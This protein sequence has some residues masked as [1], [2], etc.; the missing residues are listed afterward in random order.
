[1]KKIDLRSDTVT[2]P[3][4]A[5]RDAMYKAEL[6]D[7]VYGED[8]TVNLLQER[9]AQL[10]G[11]DAALF[12]ASGTM[13][14]LTAVLSH[15]QR[16]DEV[17][18]GSR[19][20]IAIW[21]QAGASAFGGVSLRTIANEADG[22]L[23]LEQINLCINEDDPHRTQT[24][25]IALENTFNGQPLMPA[26][27]RMVK[28]LALQNGLAVHLDGAR[29]FNASRVLLASIEEFTTHV[30]SVQFCFSKGLAAPVGSIIC[31][32]R[33]FITKAKRVRKA[34]G[35]GMR[36]AGVLA[37]GCL[38]ALDNMVER[39]DLDHALAN[40]LADGLAQIPGIKVAPAQHRTNMVF[41]ESDRNDL[42]R[43]ELARRLRDV[44]VL[45]AVEGQLGIRA[46][47]H[48][49]LTVEDIEETIVRVENLMAVSAAGA[50]VH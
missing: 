7:D 3:P 33:E 49:G 17:I 41:F 43:A 21:E 4:Q 34:L 10:S 27:M 47:T 19:S 12:V 15:C 16:S 8:P 37:A 24:K 45:V 18:L 1:M 30:D 40:Q 26:Y 25:L 35:G 22:T 38:W 50:A 32:N 46:V 42:S 44:G 2:L 14:N 5:M 11:K 29:L 13:G 36:Q 6:G 39:L 28:E 23:S 9:C 31:G 20:H 48:F